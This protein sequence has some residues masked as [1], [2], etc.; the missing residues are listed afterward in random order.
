MG[1]VEAEC[2]IEYEHQRTYKSSLTFNSV[3]DKNSKR[4][5]TTHQCSHTYRPNLKNPISNRERTKKYSL[6]KPAKNQHQPL[7]QSNTNQLP[8]RPICLDNNRMRIRVTNDNDKRQ[9]HTIM[10]PFI[11]K[12]CRTESRPNDECWWIDTLRTTER[13][14]R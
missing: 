14:V 12:S 13:P 6:R 8:R 3:A 11:F 5:Q 10:I 7:E 9:I 1:G 4:K 2:K